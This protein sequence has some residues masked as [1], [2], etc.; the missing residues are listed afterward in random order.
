MFHQHFKI[1]KDAHN[2]Q[3]C[4]INHTYHKDMSYYCT[5]NLHKVYF[6]RTV[7]YVTKTDLMSLQT[8]KASDRYLV[9][10]ELKN[11]H[12]QLKHKH[13]IRTPAN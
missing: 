5:F 3:V 8:L 2:Y 7:S 1:L 13:K 10:V 12:K 6:L 4:D 9:E 11:K